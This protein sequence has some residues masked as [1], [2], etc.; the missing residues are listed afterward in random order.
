[1]APIWFAVIPFNTHA[2]NMNNTLTCIIRLLQDVTT[3]IRNDGDTKKASIISKQKNC[4]KTRT[5]VVSQQVI[6]QKSESMTQ[7]EKKNKKM[8]K[9]GTN[10]QENNNKI[11]FCWTV[12]NKSDSHH[13]TEW[14]LITLIINQHVVSKIIGCGFLHCW[15]PLHAL[16]NEIVHSCTS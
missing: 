15:F 8:W 3:C 10:D 14:N 11:C 7:Q 1:M 4:L 5:Y 12:P 2:W 6:K 9:E 16:Y 13:P